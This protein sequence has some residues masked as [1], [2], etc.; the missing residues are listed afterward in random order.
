MNLGMGEF[1]GSRNQKTN[2]QQTMQDTPNKTL[3]DPAANAAFQTK[4]RVDVALAAGTH[5]ANTIRCTN[6]GGKHE[7]IIDSNWRKSDSMVAPLRRSKH[8]PQATEHGKV[9]WGKEERAD[10]T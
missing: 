2:A 1:K 8:I 5:K 10:V 6:T 9:S 3:P 7:T 4:G